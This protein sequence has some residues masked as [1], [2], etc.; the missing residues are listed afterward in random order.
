MARVTTR[1]AGVFDDDLSRSLIGS[2]QTSG[3]FPGSEFLDEQVGELER[4]AV[5]L[6]ADRA[7]GR[8]AGELRV[9]DDRLAVEDDRQP[10]PPERDHEPVPLAGGLV[11]LGLRD[12]AGADLGG[13]L[14]VG[15]RC[16]LGGRGSPR[17]VTMCGPTRGRWG[18]SRR[19]AWRRA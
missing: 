14:L 2:T 18:R 8:E 13:H 4:V 11:G 1:I 5:M 9:V 16:L 3:L 7:A 10:V 15:N 19:P 12:G 6:E 17:P